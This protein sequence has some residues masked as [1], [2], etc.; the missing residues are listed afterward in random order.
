MRRRFIK[1]I[2]DTYERQ[3]KRQTRHDRIRLSLEGLTL[4]AIVGGVVAAVLNL[5][6]LSESVNQSRRS[7]DAA[8]DQVYFGQRAYLLTEN[9]RL[10]GEHPVCTTPTELNSLN[11]AL[12]PDV[13]MWLQWDI[14][15][16]GQTPAHNIRFVGFFYIGPDRP[17]LN[18]EV[19]TEGRLVG[20]ALGS[21]E[22]LPSPDA[23]FMWLD[24]E[25]GRLWTDADTQRV[26]N[27]EQLWAAVYV[28]YDTVFEGVRG[29]S[30][31]CG[32]YEGS[33]FTACGTV[34]R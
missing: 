25:S 34:M 3:Q 17:P 23:A 26:N 33:R 11:V 22:C 24:Q 28:V 21:G 10:I 9:L 6:S 31:V 7:A 30:S 18:V 2:K 19:L 32:Y 12:L 20:S 27:G 4:L 16:T 5:S 14:I 13:R 29:Y 15:N 1:T 8:R